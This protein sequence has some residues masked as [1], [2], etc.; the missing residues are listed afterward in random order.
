MSQE[1]MGSMVKGMSRKKFKGGYAKKPLS[2]LFDKNHE[3][4]L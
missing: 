1:Y 2:L 3:N 4:G